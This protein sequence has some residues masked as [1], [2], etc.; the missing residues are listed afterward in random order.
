MILIVIIG[1]GMSSLIIPGLRN[2]V[3]WSYIEYENMFR[4]TTDNPNSYVSAIIGAFWA[5]SGYDATCDIVEEIKEP[6]NRNMLGSAV[7]S[8]LTVSFVYILTNFSYFLLLSPIEFLSTDA[9]AITF[10]EKFSVGFAFVIKAFVCLS[11]FGSI[12][13]G[14]INGSRQALAAARRG[15]MPRQLSLVNVDR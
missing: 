1:F 2:D 8:M 9:V 5:Y 6:F 10:G 14:L 15:Q 4:G 12:N 7:I 11:I 13:V 3:A